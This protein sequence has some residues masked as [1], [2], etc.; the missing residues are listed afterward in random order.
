MPRKQKPKP[1]VEHLLAAIADLGRQGIEYAQLTASN[2][3]LTQADLPPEWWSQEM[4]DETGRRLTDGDG[5]PA[6]RLT[7]EQS[8]AI[9][10]EQHTKHVELFYAGERVRAMAGL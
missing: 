8:E 3:M 5:I 6:L 7:S 9:G 4:I 1:P 2:F 10:R